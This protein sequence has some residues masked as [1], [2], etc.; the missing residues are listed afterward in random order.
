MAVGANVIIQLKRFCWDADAVKNSKV[1]KE[2]CPCPVFMMLNNAR[3]AQDSSVGAL[4]PVLSI[5]T[6]P[7][8]ASPLVAS[9]SRFLSF[10]GSDD[11][12]QV[13][14]AN[15]ALSHPLPDSNVLQLQRDGCYSLQQSRASHVCA[16]V[17]LEGVRDFNNKY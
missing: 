9:T 13:V 12:C 2:S 6:S 7:A 16:P 10:E 8:P 5:C 11:G 3:N 17:Q 4:S 15:D 1:R 14:V